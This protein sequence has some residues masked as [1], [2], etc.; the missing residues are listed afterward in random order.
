[1]RAT[2]ESAWLSLQRRMLPSVSQGIVAAGTAHA[3]RFELRAIWP[4]RCEPEQGLIEA[5]RQAMTQRVTLVQHGGDEE[6]ATRVSRPMIVDGRPW[7]APWPS[8]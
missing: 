4:E 2:P 5:A 7:A 1:M 3:D 8:G 6:H